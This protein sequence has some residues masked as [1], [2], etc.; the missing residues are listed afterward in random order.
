MIKA[1]IT[2]VTG[3]DASYLAELLLDK[4]YEVHGTIRRSSSFNTGRIDHI[5]DKI[6][7]HFA[8]LSDGSSLQSLIRYIGPD[9]VYHLASQSHVRVSFDLP[10]YTADVTGLGTLRI[11]EAI[12]QNGA[13]NTRF[14]YAGSSEMFGN[15]PCPQSES[16]PLRPRSP[17]GCAKCFGHH[18][19]RNYREGYNIFACSGILFNHESPRRGETFVTRKITTGAA[20][21]SLG[22]QDNLFLG[23]LEAKRDWGYAPDYVKAMWMMLQQDKPDDYVIATGESHSVKEFLHEAFD[24]LDLTP[25]AHVYFDPKYLRPTEVEFLQGDASKAKKELGWEPTVTFRELVKLMV[26][27][28]MKHEKR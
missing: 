6:H 5:F 18:M 14:Y 21:I 12:R 10:E 16:T 23:N 2:G 27:E 1:L 20:R 13:D 17:Y 26:D 19:V 9:E 15:A 22:L 3:Q 24:Y 4:G 11:L 8:D 25:S 28:A 7:C